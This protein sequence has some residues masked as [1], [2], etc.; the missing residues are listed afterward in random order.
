MALPLVGLK[1]VL[2]GPRQLMKLFGL[3]VVLWRLFVLAVV[4]NSSI[5]ALVM[6]DK[7]KKFCKGVLWIVLTIW[8]AG[9]TVAVIVMMIM[10][11]LGYMPK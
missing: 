10:A 9:F 6:Y 5:F 3:S 7:I 2:G 11:A 1:M 4:L 8:L